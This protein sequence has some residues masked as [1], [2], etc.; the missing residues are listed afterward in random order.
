[1][2]SEWAAG[3][4]GKTS[5]KE[6]EV[7]FGRVHEDVQIE[8]LAAAAAS[9]RSRAFAIGSG[10]C[11]AFSL[12]AL[13]FERVDAV[14]INP[15]QV[16]LINLKRSILERRRREDCIRAFTEDARDFVKDCADS[17]SA[18][19]RLFWE[20]R[21]HRCRR[22]LFFSGAAENAF[23]WLI[24][25][26]FTFVCSR[27]RMMRL[28]NLSDRGQ[29][30]AEWNRSIDTWRWRLALRVVFNSRL[31]RF[32]YG[33]S[34]LARLP[35]HPAD[36]IDEQFH[37]A[38]TGS[39]ARHNPALWLM[40]TGAFPPESEDALPLYLRTSEFEQTRNRLNALKTT[41]AE[42]CE[43]LSAQPRASFDALALSNILELVSV[44]DARELSAAIAHAAKPGG[45]IV[46]RAIFPSVA[47]RLEANEL[48]EDIES[49]RLLR[50]RDRS[51]ICRN[52]TV[53][54]RT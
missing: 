25:L 21:L 40:F 34:I 15:A 29:Q 48:S 50:E 18:D 49:S 45:V 9:G 2:K 51:L 26:Y 24:R 43:F 46:T 41:H 23:R 39:P 35:S 4:L 53:Y 38:A 11:T 54:R 33:S 6:P 8:L 10:G 42:A 30:E 44:E 36:A 17:L 3:Q 19:C 27:S 28:L 47:P 7:I 12:L 14:D 5:R 16:H 31:L 37:A 20:R 52:A 13:G 22:G 32:A 1:M